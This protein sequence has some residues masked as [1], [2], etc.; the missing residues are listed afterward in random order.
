MRV[1][2]A[3]ML[4]AL[5]GLALALPGSAFAASGA[6]IY[7]PDLNARAFATSDGGWERAKDSH[8]L[9]IA[10]LTCPS[11]GGGFVAGGGSYGPAD[12]YLETTIS[13]L[14]GVG[15]ESRGVL[16]SPAFTYRGVNGQRPTAL[17]FGLNHLSDI[18][19]LL[20]VAGNQVDYSVEIFPAG[21]GGGAKRIVDTKPL[22]PSE[23]WTDS[24]LVELPGSAGDR[25]GV[26]VPDHHPVR[27]RRRGDPRRQRRL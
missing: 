26:Q 16:K 20:A 1:I 2:K 22:I 8:G 15:S 17:V 18:S 5:S 23:D 19:A 24:A 11:I 7:H 14:T 4:V 13:G 6:A 10:P 25:P 9:C 3:G 12:G 27:L 21:A